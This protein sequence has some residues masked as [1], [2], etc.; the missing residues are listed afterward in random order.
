M[1]EQPSSP[2]PSM[3]GI[4]NNFL[5]TVPVGQVVVEGERRTINEAKVAELMESIQ[6]VGV[7]NPIVV[8]RKVRT[9]RLRAPSRRHAPVRGNEAARY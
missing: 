2:A 8:E 1:N 6:S 5:I 7:L 4:E 3:K 9:E